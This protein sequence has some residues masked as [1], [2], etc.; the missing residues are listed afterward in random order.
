MRDNVKTYVE[1][2]FKPAWRTEAKNHWHPCCQEHP[3]SPIQQSLDAAS[4]TEEAIALS[5][6]FE[7][8]LITF[9]CPKGHEYEAPEPF[10]I[11]TPDLAC[12]SGPICIYCYVTW[13]H[14]NL[15]TEEFLAK[16]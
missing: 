13:L 6:D 3:D 10:I 12:N 14:V 16:D 2:M 11:L 15:G 7:R 5:E 4:Y 8:T 9:K 1:R